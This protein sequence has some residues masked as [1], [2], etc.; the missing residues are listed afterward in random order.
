GIEAIARMRRWKLRSRALVLSMFDDQT[1]LRAALAAGASG[2]VPKRAA[3]K[4]L[5]EAVRQISQNH[6]Y[7]AV[8]LSD[9]SLEQL[10][11]SPE[12][13]PTSPFSCLTDREHEVL[14]LLAQ[15]HTHSEIGQ[16]LQLSSKTIDTYRQRVNQKLGLRT[17]ADLVRFAIETGLLTPLRPPEVRDH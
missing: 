1:Y 4:Q 11:S 17:R 2:Y 7:I 5:L 16:R 3:G 15:G 8:S 9:G 10:V 12:T 13:M 14:E 6:S